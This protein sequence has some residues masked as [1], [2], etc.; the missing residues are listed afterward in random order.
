MRLNYRTTLLIY[1]PPK[2]FSKSPAKHIWK[3][4]ADAQY[5]LGF[6]YKNGRGVEQDDIEAI[7]VDFRINGTRQTGAVRKMKLPFSCLVGAVSNCAD[8]VRL[9][10]APTGRRKCFFIF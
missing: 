9:Q 4:H 3:G 10:T 1:W 7:I 6:M 2:G 8:A 5:N